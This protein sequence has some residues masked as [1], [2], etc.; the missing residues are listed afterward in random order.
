[1]TLAQTRDL[2]DRAVAADRAVLALNVITV[3]HAE[4]VVIGAERADSAVILQLSERAIDFHGGRIAPLVC[5]A[6]GPSK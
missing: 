4:A 5:S 2:L 3:E 6:L 1:M